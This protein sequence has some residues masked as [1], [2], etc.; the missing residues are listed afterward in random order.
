MAE[1]RGIPLRLP[2]VEPRSRLAWEATE[3]AREHGKAEAM[4][5]AL[6]AAFFETGWDI[7][8]Q[9]VLW[10]IGESV[11]LDRNRLREALETGRYTRR[12]LDDEEQAERY[13][14]SGATGATHSSGGPRDKFSEHFGPQ[15]C[16]TLRSGSICREEGFR[17]H[18]PRISEFET[19][20]SPVQKR[21]RRRGRAWLSW[22]MK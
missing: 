22:P 9:E 10:T 12:V 5:H 8:Q 18:C 3:F 21:R 15:R 13:G 1:Q 11:G 14:L 2:P 7:G 20:K 19:V 16:A 17:R 4:N 6:F